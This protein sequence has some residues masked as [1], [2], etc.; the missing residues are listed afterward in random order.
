MSSKGL[1][2]YSKYFPFVNNIVKHYSDGKIVKIDDKCYNPVLCPQDIKL[3]D[4]SKKY[5]RITRQEPGKVY[6]L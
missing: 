3:E 4:T 5:I 2:K 1:F 6:D